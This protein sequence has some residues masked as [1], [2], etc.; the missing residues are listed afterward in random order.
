MRKQCSFRNAFL[1]KTKSLHRFRYRLG[2][3]YVDQGFAAGEC[4]RTGRFRGYPA[5]ATHSALRCRPNAI[6]KTWQDVTAP[7]PACANVRCSKIRQAPP[8]TRCGN[9]FRTVRPM[10]MRWEV[11]D[12]I[13]GSFVS[14]LR[15]RRSNTKY[16]IVPAKTI[17]AL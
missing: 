12:Q 1:Q 17:C 6:A 4:K 15:K 13:V 14:C 16:R 3:Q 11:P 7:Q 9:V 8:P 2:C 10:R 5:F